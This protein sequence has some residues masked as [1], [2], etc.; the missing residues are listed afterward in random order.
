VFRAVRTVA[1]SANEA[2]GVGGRRVDVVP[3]PTDDDVAQRVALSRV[4]AL[5]GGFAI[6]APAGIP[7]LV[8]ADVEP[9]GPDVVPGEV[10]AEQAGRVLGA[11]LATRDLA[12]P[13]GAVVGEGPDAGFATGLA[14]SVPVER[15]SAGPDTGCDDEVIALR[16]RGVSALAVAGPPDLARSCTAAAARMGWRPPGGLLVAPSAAYA[17]LE[18]AFP[19][20]GARTVLGFPSPRAD[21]P[22]ASRYRRTVSYSGAYRALVS[23]AA[24]EL[25]LDVARVTGSVA[26]GPVRTRH[27]K[28]D[29]YDLDGG[30]N[31]SPRIV[32]ARFARWTTD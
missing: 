15:V 3:V 27:W 14:A 26:A 7:W 10:S 16:R 21:E 24:A 6:P 31:A 25:A 22:G 20:Q 30:R 1:D 13:A 5:V 12:G 4:D 29:L 11:D 18:L 9:S 2:G 19:A 17:H 23:F 28:S 32:A 8:P